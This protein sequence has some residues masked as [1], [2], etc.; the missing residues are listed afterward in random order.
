MK[1]AYSLS[2]NVIVTT[3]L[4]LIVLVILIAVFT[5]RV[6]Q[7]RDDLGHLDDDCGAAGG[8]CVTDW[9]EC[10]DSDGIVLSNRDC[11]YDEVCCLLSK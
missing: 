4:A 2:M 6:G 10:Y 11:N 9:D 3:V 8:V 7:G 1:K 5:D